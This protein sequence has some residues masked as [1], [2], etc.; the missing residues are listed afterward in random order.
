MWSTVLILVAQ[1]S[2]SLLVFDTP[3]ADLFDCVP[4]GP[5]RSRCQGH[6]ITL[7]LN[8]PGGGGTVAVTICQKVGQTLS[9]STVFQPAGGDNRQA[10]IVGTCK[11]VV[12]PNQGSDWEDVRTCSD[13]TYSCSDT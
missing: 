13:I 6:T 1:L 2:T 10:S 8:N 3:P 12:Q 7:D 11:M 9:C 5:C 4:S